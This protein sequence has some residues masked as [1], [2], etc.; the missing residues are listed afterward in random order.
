VTVINIQQW[1]GCW[2]SGSLPGPGAYV[3]AESQESVTYEA[4]TNSET[5]KC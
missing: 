3:W 4:P 1:N 2:Q 5:G